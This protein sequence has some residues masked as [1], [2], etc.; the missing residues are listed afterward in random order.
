[1]TA[2]SSHCRLRVRYVAYEANP[3]NSKIVPSTTNTITKV[4]DPGELVELIAAPTPNPAAFPPPFR[5]TIVEICMVGA[6]A[7][8]SH[9]DRNG[10][11]SLTEKMN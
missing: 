2:S 1:M 6:I 9:T 3:S 7:T 4:I 10:D 8:R 5:A 11:Y